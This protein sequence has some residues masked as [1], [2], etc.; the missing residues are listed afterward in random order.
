[1]VRVQLLHEAYSLIEWG[2]PGK[3]RFKLRSVKIQ[4][5]NFMAASTLN[6]DDAD[7]TR[8]ELE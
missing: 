3:V 2:V 7:T 5:I 6:I 1:M 4:K 8:L